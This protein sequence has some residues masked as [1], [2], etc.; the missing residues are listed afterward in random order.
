MSHDF[1]KLIIKKR[2]W[3]L[4]DWRN[5]FHLLCAGD[6]EGGPLP[7]RMWEGKHQNKFRA[8]TAREEMGM[9]DR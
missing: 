2:N 1:D 6:G 3:N 4:N 5:L 9:A 7:L 8:L